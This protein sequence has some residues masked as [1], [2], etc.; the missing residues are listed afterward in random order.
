MKSSDTG[1]IEPLRMQMGQRTFQP[2]RRI[3]GR[4]GLYVCLLLACVAVVTGLLFAAARQSVITRNAKWQTPTNASVLV[5]SL[6][7][8]LKLPAAEL[9]LTDVALINLLSAQELPGAGELNISNSLV[10]LDQWAKR[11]QT[12]TER[13]LYRFRANPAEFE[14]SEGYFRML[15]MSVVFYEDFGIRYNPQRMSSPDQ[16]DLND[17]FFA[18]SQDIFLHGLL[19][20]R[21]MGT[22]SS[23]PVLYAAVGRRLGYPLK[24]VTTKAHLFLRWQDGTERFNLEATGRGMNRYD[25]EHFKRWPFPVSEEEIRADGYLKSLTA[26]EELAVFLSLRGNCLKEAGRLWE[27]ATCYAQAVRLAPGSRSYALLLADVRQRGTQLPAQGAVGARVL[28]VDPNP[29]RSL[30]PQ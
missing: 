30:K 17:R 2:D 28:T 11:V 26:A 12:E 25:D 27:A 3:R 14:N 15:M 6:T 1:P 5:N 18:D 10:T 7:N 8:L 21:R 13:H 23:L 24:L 20:N 22:C 16:I 4:V 9:E 29:M 19:G